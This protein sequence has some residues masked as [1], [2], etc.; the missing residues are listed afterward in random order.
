MEAFLITK[1]KTDITKLNTTI[2]ATKTPKTF[3]AVLSI[4]YGIQPNMS[5][6]SI[7]SR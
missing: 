1:Q 3:S 6:I 4:K 7:S 5:V 2:K